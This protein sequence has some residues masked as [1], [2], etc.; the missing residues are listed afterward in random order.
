M[1]TFGIQMSGDVEAEEIVKCFK[2][3]FELNWIMSSRIIIPKIKDM[4]YILA[5]KCF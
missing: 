1:E 3:I 4:L 2:K 5:L